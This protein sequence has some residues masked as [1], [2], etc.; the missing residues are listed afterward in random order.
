MSEFKERQTIARMVK[1]LLDR[2]DVWWSP[3]IVPGRWETVVGDDAEN[4]LVRWIEKDRQNHCPPFAAQ[5]PL[6]KILRLK[7]S[8]AP[9][10]LWQVAVDLGFDV[11]VVDLIEQPGRSFSPS[12][13]RFG[14]ESERPKQD[15]PKTLPLLAAL[16][17][18]LTKDD[19]TEDG[20]SF[21]WSRGEPRLS[22]LFENYHIL[23]RIERDATQTSANLAPQ[24]ASDVLSGDPLLNSVD[25]ALAYAL[26]AINLSRRGAGRLSVIDETCPLALLP[27]GP[28]NIALDLQDVP[29]L[30]PHAVEGSNGWE[31]TCDAWMGTGIWRL[32]LEVNKKADIDVLSATRVAHVP[33]RPQE[34]WI[35]KARLFTSPLSDTLPRSYGKQASG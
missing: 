13:H 11:G 2:D 1:E 17:P 33:E 34:V 9:V 16:S 25:D 24:N 23:P 19:D 4:F 18:P 7:P 21:G 22:Y 12:L 15:L 6:L 3:L 10:T 29:L 27:H 32:V 26:F 30:A 20:Y 35:G 14:R 31:V 8:F 28:H 5:F